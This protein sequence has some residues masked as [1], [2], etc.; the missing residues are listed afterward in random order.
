MFWIAGHCGRDDISRLAVLL[1]S[2]ELSVPT[3]RV[4][5]VLKQFSMPKR[6]TEVRYG[7]MVTSESGQLTKGE[8][9]LFGSITGEAV[10]DSFESIPGYT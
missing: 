8:V 7:V 10:S 1:Q 9:R 3:E 2:R 4:P 6:G 5:E